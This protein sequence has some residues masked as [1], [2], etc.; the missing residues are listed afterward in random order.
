[1]EIALENKSQLHMGIL[2]RDS[3]IQDTYLCLSA[4]EAWGGEEKHPLMQK[5][6]KSFPFN[7]SLL[8][9]QSLLWVAVSVHAAERERL[10]DPRQNVNHSLGSPDGCA[11]LLKGSCG[12]SKAVQSAQNCPDELFELLPEECSHYQ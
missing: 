2:A 11:L 6:V 1:M 7:I 9:S 10:R 8:Q 5:P 3:S 12:E 4:L